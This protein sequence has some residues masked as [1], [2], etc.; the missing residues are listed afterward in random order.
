MF[1]TQEKAN[2]RCLLTYCTSEYTHS[3]EGKCF[4]FQ[5]E[6]TPP[7]TNSQSDI[8]FINGGP[9][10]LEAHGGVLNSTIDYGTVSKIPVYQHYL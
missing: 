5:R 9:C 10:T 4:N 6:L 1:T 2:M 3:S 8:R 7:V